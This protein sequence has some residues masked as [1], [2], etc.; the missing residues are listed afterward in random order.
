MQELYEN[1]T[2]IQMQGIPAVLGKR[3]IIGIAPTGSGK[4]LSFALPIIS[5]LKEPMNLRA[6]IISPTKELS[7]QLFKEFLVLTEN[8][9]LKVE[10]LSKK[11]E[12]IDTVKGKIDIIVSSPLFMLH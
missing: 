6:L 1:M 8:T 10:L 7:R 12:E 4:T 3:D 2:P 11:T 9:G 5:L